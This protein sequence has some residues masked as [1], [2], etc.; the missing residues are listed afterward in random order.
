LRA[1]LLLPR[2]AVAASLFVLAL[3]GAPSAAAA[4]GNARDLS[5]VWWT[6]KYIPKIE[7]GFSAVIFWPEAKPIYDKNVAGLKNGTVVDS[8]RRNC[9]PDGVPRIMAAPYPFEIAQMSGQVTLRFEVNNATRTVIMDKPLP[10]AGTLIPADLGHSYGRWDRDTLIVETIGFTDNTFL[11]ATGLPHSDQL[12]V[13]EYFWKTGTGGKRLQ[14]VA[15]II[16]PKIYWQP[17]VQRH[18][19]E[20][21]P[22]VR[23]AH[24][25]CGGKN[26]DIAHVAGS[27][28]WK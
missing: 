20:R 7:P 28:G 26:R 14:Y 27:A 16:D 5:G 19:Y 6:E 22:D 4:D 8:A 11:D 25:A 1:G 15:M 13:K 9:T 24:Y 23:I 2:A 12:H 21:R 18:S 10:A 3:A 17:F